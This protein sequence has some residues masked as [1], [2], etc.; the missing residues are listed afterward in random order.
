MYA[1][2]GGRAARD[3]CTMRPAQRAIARRYAG[4]FHQGGAEYV[5]VT[6]STPGRWVCATAPNA[7]PQIHRPRLARLAGIAREFRRIRRSAH[8]EHAMTSK[9]RAAFAAYLLAGIATVTMQPAHADTWDVPFVGDRIQVKAHP[10]SPLATFTVSDSEGNS[11]DV[12]AT[13]GCDALPCGFDRPEGTRFLTVES[14]DPIFVISRTREG[15]LLPAFRRSAEPPDCE[16]RRDADEASIELARTA[17]TSLYS[18]RNNFPA[19]SEQRTE[20]DAAACSLWSSTLASART[21]LAGCAVW[22]GRDQALAD[23]RGHVTASHC[24]A[25]ASRS[26][27]A[28]NVP[29][30]GTAVSIQATPGTSPRA[31][32][33]RVIADN[34]DDAPISVADRL[35]NV[36]VRVHPPDRDEVSAY[37]VRRAVVCDRPCR[38]CRDGTNVPGL[39]RRARLAGLRDT[40]SRRPRV[41]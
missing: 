35:P 38:R 37:R 20:Y 4:R 2:E 1:T 36:P 31:S 28:W 9:T 25:T 17:L 16:A 29:F 39:Q 8:Q 33:I 15:R 11:I 26:P 3:A 41:S 22:D 6:P 34:R 40:S 24:E 30:I 10:D 32:G 12:P 14:D 27:Y 5:T 7:T 23:F 13:A 19:E 18:V 21:S